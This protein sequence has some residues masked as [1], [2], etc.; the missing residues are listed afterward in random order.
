MLYLL[1]IKTVLEREREEGE[2]GEE[3]GREKGRGC[4]V[5]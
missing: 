5:I 1:V 4:G 2:K 3:E